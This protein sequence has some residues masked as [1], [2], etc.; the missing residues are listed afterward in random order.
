MWSQSE[1]Q[2][3]VETFRR[4]VFGG[5][6]NLTVMADCV[7]I[8]RQSCKEVHTDIYMYMYYGYIGSKMHADTCKNVKSESCMVI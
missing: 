2:S 8:V 5:K 7:C 6:S 1:L 3:F 4:Q